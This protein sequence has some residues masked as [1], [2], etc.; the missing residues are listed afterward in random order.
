MNEYKGK[1]MKIID[2]WTAMSGD[3]QHKF[4]LHCVLKGIRQGRWL[5][6]GNELGDAVNSA[7]VKVAESLLDPDKLARNI[8]RRASQ[9]FTESLAAIVI[10]AAKAV[11]QR[12]IDREK[13]NSAAVNDTATND[14]GEEFSLLDTIA[15]A[16]DTEQSAT[17]R[18][19]LKSFYADLDERNKV[20]L[21]G[22]AEG[23]T[24]REIASYL[25]ITPTAV[26][27]RAVKVR[28]RLKE[29]L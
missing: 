11:L 6:N 14:G 13:R 28:A 25:G 1:A 8:E 23:K 7:Y 19:T 2:E 22:M 24:E 21:C 12:E 3:E 18:A 27:H 26:H 17:I 5:A 29:L 15:G 9:G 20:V 16:A 10:R 4:C